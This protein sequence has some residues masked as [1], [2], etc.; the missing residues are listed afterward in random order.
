MELTSEFPIEASIFEFVISAKIVPPFP[1]FPFAET[2]APVLTIESLEDALTVTFF[3]A[4][5]F[6]PSFIC[7]LTSLTA[8][9]K[10]I[11]PAFAFVF[12]SGFA[13]RV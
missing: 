10:F 8:R 13:A 1:D 5:I 11:P 12:L 4:F 9:F 6:A 3:S 7:A 2:T